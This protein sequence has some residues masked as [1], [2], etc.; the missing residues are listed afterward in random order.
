[1]PFFATLPPPFLSVVHQP[2]NLCLS[3]SIFVSSLE[4]LCLYESIV[5]LDTVSWLD[6]WGKEVQFC[7]RER[8]ISKCQLKW[9]RKYIIHISIS[10][11]LPLLWYFFYNMMKQ[12]ETAE[13]QKWHQIAHLIRL[14]VQN[15]KL[16]NYTSSKIMNTSKSSHCKSW[17][18]ISTIVSELYESQYT[19]HFNTK[20]NNGSALTSSELY[21]FSHRDASCAPNATLQGTRCT[22][23]FQLPVKAAG[24]SNLQWRGP[25]YW[26]NVGGKTQTSQSYQSR[27]NDFLSESGWVHY[28]A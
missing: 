2:C 23:G 22:L 4:L 18:V 28:K 25:G 9:S 12:R 16:F 8:V 5:F 27:M 17:L 13:S 21:F 10:S 14:T 3:G 19:Y 26:W 7:L 11:G 20:I 15:P 24:V 1:M 6:T